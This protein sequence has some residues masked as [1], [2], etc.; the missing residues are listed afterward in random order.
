MRDDG[1]NLAELENRTDQ[2]RVIAMSLLLV[3]GASYGAYRF[4]L[5]APFRPDN[6]IL[7]WTTIVWFALSAAETFNKR[8]GQIQIRGEAP[9]YM[10]YPWMHALMLIVRFP[11]F[12]LLLYMNWKW[13]LTLYVLTFALAVSPILETIGKALMFL[14][15][16][17]R[18][19]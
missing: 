10:E 18:I 16:K 17:K 15:L 6:P 13:A 8:M 1:P 11:L 5:F 7:F 9:P 3:A 12:V 14:W 4:G 2:R 19:D